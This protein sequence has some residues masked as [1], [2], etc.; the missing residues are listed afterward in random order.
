MNILNLTINSNV[1]KLFIHLQVIYGT[2]KYILIDEK[3]LVSAQSPYA[4]TKLLQIK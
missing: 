1:K 4:A 3:H 2:P